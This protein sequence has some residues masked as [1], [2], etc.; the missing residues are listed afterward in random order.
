MTVNLVVTRFVQLCYTQIHLKKTFRAKIVHADNDDSNEQTIELLCCRN[1]TFSSVDKALNYYLDKP[2]MQN[3]A[4]V[5]QKYSI[6][7]PKFY[8]LL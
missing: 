8:L 5:R 1:W 2:R 6:K 4:Q 7:M 3:C